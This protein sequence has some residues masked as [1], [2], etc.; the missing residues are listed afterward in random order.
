MDIGKEMLY[1]FLSFYKRKDVLIPTNE[2][3]NLLSLKETLSE[4]NLVSCTTWDIIPIFL[5]LQSTGENVV[6]H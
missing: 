4:I 1:I 3:G 5:I 6:T 2:G